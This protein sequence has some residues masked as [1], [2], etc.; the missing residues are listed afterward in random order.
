M[1]R[2]TAWR[3]ALAG[4]ATSALAAGVVWRQQRAS[5]DAARAASA[6]EPTLWQMRFDRPEGGELAMASLLGQPL[7]LNFW[8]SWCP[9]C[10]AEMPDLDRFAR[11]MAPAGWRVLGL[12]VDNPKAVRNFLATRPVG[13]LIALAGFEGADLSRRLGNSQGGLP[14]TVAFNAKGVAVQQKAGATTLA[15]LQQ[16]AR[17]QN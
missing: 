10:V 5:Q 16:W 12:A 7:L 8:G 17:M 13:Y 1:N 14:F 6:S 11:D 15:E 2:R 4:A 9:P 3:L